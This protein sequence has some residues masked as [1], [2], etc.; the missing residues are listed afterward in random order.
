MYKNS[1][2]NY[3]QDLPKF[4]EIN[5]KVM[6][7][8]SMSEP[9]I[10]RGIRADGEIVFIESFTIASPFMGENTLLSFHLDV[11]ERVEAENEVKKYQKQLQKLYSEAEIIEEQE[12]RRVAED[13]HDS[14]GQLLALAKIKM[15]MYMENQEMLQKYKKEITEIEQYIEDSLKIVKGAIFELSPPS[16]YE[17]GL[18]DALD[19]MLKKLGGKS[20]INVEFIYDRKPKTLNIEF[21][22]ILYRIIRELM[23]NTIKHSNAKNV[24]VILSTEDDIV[25][26][27][28]TD[29][30]IG[31]DVS[32]V[33]SY[34]KKSGFGLFS[35]RERLNY[36]GG[37]FDVHSEK[38]KGSKFVIE[39]P[40][41]TR[42]KF[43]W[44]SYEY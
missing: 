44:G 18:V 34:E 4:M 28:F 12:R 15:K 25:R 19:E 39:I 13:L 5:D 11:T 3:Q 31:F 22:L 2:L 16:L 36:F 10:F 1:S 20:G 17:L 24:K 27:V 21:K 32:K 6:A 26:I 42:T 8:T 37:N 30:G 33:F 9:T 23:M 38:G 29:D 7:G 41:S 40:F 43:D 14:V 35:I